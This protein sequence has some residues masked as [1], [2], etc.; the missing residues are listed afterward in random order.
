MEDLDIDSRLKE[1]FGE[2]V[3]KDLDRWVREIIQSET[4]DQYRQIL[5]RLDILEDRY[6]GISDEVYRLRGEMNGFRTEVNQKF[7]VIYQRFD[8]IRDN[9]NLRFDAM[10]GYI[11]QRIDTMN[12]SLD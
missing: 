5:S 2:D 7:D 9:I 4:T 8:A 10:K 1:K 11:E 6:K 3:V 12:I